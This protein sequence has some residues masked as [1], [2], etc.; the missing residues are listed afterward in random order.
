MVDRQKQNFIKLIES[1]RELDNRFTAI[2]SIDDEGGSGFFSIVFTADDKKTGEKVVLKFFDPAKSG[3]IDRIERFERE[4]KILFQLKDE[5]SIINIIGTGIRYLPKELEDTSTGIRINLQCKYIA[6]ELADLNIASFIYAP[7][8]IDALTNLYVFRELIK[9]VFRLHNKNICHRD[10]K[11]DN[12][13]IKGKKI[14][15][16]DL[17]TIKAMDNSMPDIRIEY[18][19]PV[20]H[21]G[22]W[23]PELFFGLGIADELVYKADI[24]AIGA[25]L[26]ELFTKNIYTQ[27]VY[28]DQVFKN[29]DITKNVLLRMTKQNRM[30]T[31]KKISNDLS[32]L[33]KPPDIYSYN[34]HIPKCIRTRLNKLYKSLVNANSAKRLD[35]QISIFRQIN[36]CIIRLENEIKYNK[37]LKEKKRRRF[38]RL[39]KKVAT[40]SNIKGNKNDNQ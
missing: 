3:S 39:N 36:I 18:F 35:N 16:S 28:N 22:Y 24:F 2:K 5:P 11:P 23:A 32:K 31:Y 19:D 8:D 17:G 33:I 30:A 40:R 7:G 34:G 13:L 26:F 38:I 15:L 37:W 6:L 12:F 14:L 25:I 29:F 21:S 10:L 1:E 20:G 4:A 27:Q 9:S